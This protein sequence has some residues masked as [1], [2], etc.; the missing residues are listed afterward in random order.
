MTDPERNSEFFPEKLNVSWDE[1]EG[2]IEIEGKEKFTV[3]QG[4]TQSL[5]VIQ[6]NKTNANFEKRREIPATTSGLLWSCAILVNISQLILN[7]FLFKFSQ[8][9]PLMAF[10]RKQFHCYMSCEHELA[11]EW[12]CGN[13]KNAS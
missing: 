6:Q 1:V 13:M 8:C 10:G 7:C 3:P 4:T 5:F 2:N 9:C 11:N 12:A